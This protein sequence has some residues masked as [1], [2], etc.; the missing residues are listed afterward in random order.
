MCP[1]APP[2]GDLGAHHSFAVVDLAHLDLMLLEL[3]VRTLG[4]FCAKNPDHGAASH[5]QDSSQDDQHD[6]GPLP[7]LT[8]FGKLCRTVLAYLELPEVVELGPMELTKVVATA[9]C[10]PRYAARV[11]PAA[12]TES[13]QS[14]TRL[15]AIVHSVIEVSYADVEMILRLGRLI[16]RPGAAHFTLA[17]LCAPRTRYH[18]CIL[19]LI[20]IYRHTGVHLLNVLARV[21]VVSIDPELFLLL[22]KGMTA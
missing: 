9:I 6:S 19:V 2:L 15:F 22:V 8:I 21:V 3:L 20:V 12:F 17:L 11:I 7:Q 13:S 14:A 4:L 5:K 1:L 16:L 10:T 18:R